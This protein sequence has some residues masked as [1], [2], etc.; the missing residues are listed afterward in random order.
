MHAPPS[1]E[2]SPDVTGVQKQG[3]YYLE[4][5]PWNVEKLVVL[6]G[7]KDTIVEAPVEN[8]KQFAI[9]TMMDLHG[10]SDGPK[11]ASLSDTQELVISS[12]LIKPV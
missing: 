5:N 3:N 9:S 8:A 1:W 7:L 12:S 2:P 11:D 10:R 6:E 4:S